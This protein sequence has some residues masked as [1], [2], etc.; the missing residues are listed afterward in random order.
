MSIKWLVL[1]CNYLCHR[2]KHVFGGLGYGDTP[3]GVIYGFLKT[4]PAFQERFDTKY[5]IFC[6]DSKTNL[7]EEILPTY[8]Q[9]RKNKVQEWT[10]EELKF[11]NAFRIQ[12]KRLRRVYLKK[13][14]YRNVFCQKGYESD[15]IIA[16]ICINLPMKDEAII[17]SSD[18]D[19][20]QLIRHNVSFHN[21]QKAKTITLQG[22]MK[23]YGIIPEQW[24]VVK[25]LAGCDTDEVPGIKGIGEKTVLKY[26]K[27][28]LKQTTKAFRKIKRL[29]TKYI[30]KNYPLVVLPFAN[31][32]NFRLK[33]D[34]LS[35]KGWIE[36][37]NSLGMKSIR[38]R[39]PK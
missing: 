27:G 20:Y 34:R 26:L 17:I 21:P 31:T 37:T 8:K 2:A 19:L 30:K 33:E 32:K 35:R 1:D 13:I 11:E 10:E 24:A 28:D 25:C 29:R 16:S 7:R 23:T 18:K 5:I 22:F 6:W 14:G 36:V 15:D 12:M 9:K 3:T 39:G 4:I 38:D